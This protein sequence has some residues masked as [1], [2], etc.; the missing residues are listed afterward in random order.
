MRNIKRRA[1]GGSLREKRL[2]S[3]YF[4]AVCA[5]AVG[6]YFVKNYCY[7]V[8]KMGQPA[9]GIQAINISVF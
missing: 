7:V 2:F 1:N 4:Q 9:T 8:I 5:R 6:P 3:P